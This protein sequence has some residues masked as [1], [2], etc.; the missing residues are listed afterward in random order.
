[1]RVDL[2]LKN[3]VFFNPYFK[4]FVPG[5]ATVLDG[6]FLHIG[7]GE[8][9]MEQFEADEIVDCEG[10]FVVPGL[11]DIHMHIESSQASPVPFT[12]YL[13][14]YGITTIVSEPHEIANVFG[15]EAILAMIEAG[16]GSPV[17]V[18]YGISSSV[19]STDDTLETTG[20][21]ID[22]DDVKALMDNPGIACLG[23]VMNT[24]AV[25][26]EPDCKANQFTSFLKENA[27][28]LPLE[29]HCPRIVGVDLSR[30]IYTGIDSD[31]TEHTLEEVIDRYEKGMFFELQTKML[32]PEVV[33]F[34]IENGLYEH[35]AFVT[36]DTMPDVMA[37]EGHLDRILVGARKL[38]FDRENMIYCGT[39]TP[40]RRMRMYDRGAIAPGKLA[41]FVILEDIDNFVVDKTFKNGKEVYSKDKPINYRNKQNVFPAKFYDSVHVAPIDESKFTIAADGEQK[42]VRA[43]EIIPDRTQ[44]AKQHFTLPVQNGELQWENREELALVATFERYGKNG[45][46]GYGFACGGMLKRGAVATTY[47][48]DHHNLQVA[49]HTKADMVLAAQTVVDM[50]GGMAVVE[51]GKVLAKLSLPVGGIM[52][53][54]PMEEIGADARAI[55]HA[56]EA[57]GYNNFEPIMSF[58]TISLP[59]SPDIKITDMGLIDVRSGKV[60]PLFVD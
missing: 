6:K 41:D 60:L 39:F 49:G 58:A 43:M 24:R 5:Y 33:S 35:T 51:N 37:F 54:R 42:T 34:I 57:L 17:D 14:K 26:N 50:K 31:H 36:D 1:M 8:T 18:Y 53:E 56:M 21:V 19:P 28:R 12:D 59:V 13:V 47:A 25:L 9:D 7:K 3:G 11:I 16:K 20:G 32:K 52:S 10:K 2:L 46:I 48:H 40:A 55:H 4:K 30:Y 15:L 27:P 29:G 45:N 38:G 22:L 23:E 44:T